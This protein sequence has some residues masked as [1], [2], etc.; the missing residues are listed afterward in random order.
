MEGV[1]QTVVADRPAVRQGRDRPSVDRACP[2]QWLKDQ[3]KEIDRR[4]V[5]R[6]E[7]ICRA[8]IRTGAEDD[9]TTGIRC[10]VHREH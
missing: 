7:R 10:G 3:A 9:L 4:G 8:D 5:A 2:D 1:G 6:Q